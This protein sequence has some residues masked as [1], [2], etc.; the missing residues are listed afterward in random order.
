MLGSRKINQAWAAFSVGTGFSLLSSQLGFW[1]V[2][3]YGKFQPD[4]HIPFVTFFHLE[5]NLL[6]LK[7]K[8]AINNIDSP[9]AT[10]PIPSF[11][12]LGT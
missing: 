6:N 1:L 4:C 8:Y 3:D 2:Y 9:L 11:Q 7:S 10:Q 12:P 5:K